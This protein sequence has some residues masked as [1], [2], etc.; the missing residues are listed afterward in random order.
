MYTIKQNKNKHTQKQTKVTLKSCKTA[1]VQRET[2]HCHTLLF[3]AANI[4]KPDKQAKKR[5][6]TD[7]ID[8]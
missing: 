4:A 2:E 3:V 8:V 6:M 7:E 5:R 1:K